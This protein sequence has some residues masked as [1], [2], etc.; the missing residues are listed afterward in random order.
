MI[1]GIKIDYETADRITLSV[2]K[3]DYQMV[4]EN[5]RN[6]EISKK[7]GTIAD[8]MKEDLQY[9]EELL[10]ALKKVLTY[11]MTADA[12]DAFIKENV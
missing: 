12:Y 9:D 7:N 3:E 10:E 8:H 11:Y 5:V 4:R 6:L 2:L 1:E